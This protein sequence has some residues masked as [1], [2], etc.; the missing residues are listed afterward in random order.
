MTEKAPVGYLAELR[1]IERAARGRPRIGMNERLR[2]E[3]LDLGQDPT[4]SFPSS[5]LSEPDTKARRPSMR[6]RFLGFYGAFGALPLP[7]TEEVARWVATGDRAF[8]RFTDIFATRF[9]QLFFRAHSDARRIGQFDRPDADKF[10]DWIGALGG[11]GSPAYHDRDR[12]RDTNRMPLMPLAAH[13]VKSPVRLRQMLQHHLGVPIRIDEFVPSWLIFEPDALSRLGQ[14]GCALGRDTHLGNRIRTVGDKITI[15]IEAKSLDKYTRFLPGGDDHGQLADLVHWYLG[16]R[17]E[18]D[19]ALWLPAGQV[20]PAKLGGGATLGWM[21]A[22]PTD[23]P[24]A[25]DQLLR[26]AT[27]R[28]D[29]E[30]A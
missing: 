28:L 3:L 4:M 8:V 25:A 6:V 19:I 13:R 22:L 27:Y 29:P 7:T 1:R 10:Q 11:V 9:I 18:V 20:A 30:A 16:R 5:D 24:R 23:T 12:V 17:F 21:A 14:S 15:H 26:A 2:D